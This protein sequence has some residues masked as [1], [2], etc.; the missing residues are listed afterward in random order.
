[1]DVDVCSMHVSQ[2]EGIYMDPIKV[3]VHCKENL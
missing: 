1:M 2:V 3:R